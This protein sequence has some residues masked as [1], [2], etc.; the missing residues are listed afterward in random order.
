MLPGLF[1]VAPELRAK[2]GIESD[3]AAVGAQCLQQIPQVLQAAASYRQ[4]NAGEVKDSKTLK[5]DWLVEQ[6]PGGTV[7]TPV[8][9][10][11]LARLIIVNDIEPGLTARALCH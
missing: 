10:N 9:E 3:K 4:G 11:P 2:V 1:H 7:F 6:L 8:T 5:T